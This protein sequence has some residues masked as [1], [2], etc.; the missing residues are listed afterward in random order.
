MVE[1]KQSMVVVLILAG[2]ALVILQFW[3][4]CI[5]DIISHARPEQLMM[6]FGTT[7]GICWVILSIE[8][9]LVHSLTLLWRFVRKRRET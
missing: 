2:L 5:A 7:I 4:I 6:I 3:A 8:G 1:G 9:F